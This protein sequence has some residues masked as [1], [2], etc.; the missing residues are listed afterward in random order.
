MRMFVFVLLL[1]AFIATGVAWLTTADWLV[2]VDNPLAF[3]Y[4]GATSFV[5]AFLVQ[6]DPR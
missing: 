5:A 4:F 6:S 2:S 1:A 3:F